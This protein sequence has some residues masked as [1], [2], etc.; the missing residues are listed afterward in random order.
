MSKRRK[1]RHKHKET[2]P[3]KNQS[4][5]DNPVVQTG[6]SI[7]PYTPETKNDSNHNEEEHPFWKR[8]LPRIGI[9]A[10]IAYAVITWFMYCANKR[11]ADAAHSAASTAREA[12]VTGQRA[13]V[14]N[15][16]QQKQEGNFLKIIV[17]LENNGETPTRYM[18]MH[19]SQSGVMDKPLPHDFGFPNT[20][21]DGIDHGGIKVTVAAKSSINGIEMLVPISQLQKSPAYLYV[22]G[23]ATYYD[24]FENT[25]PHILQ[26]CDDFSVHPIPYV[27]TLESADA[28][29]RHNCVDDACR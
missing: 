24:A 14:F 18:M 22:W 20:W 2:E 4:G 19:M 16:F 25:P 26:F 8:W 5:T 9:F 13:Y 1:P 21:E 17:R 3:K 29:Y 7:Q 23:W 6:Q 10:G 28:C 12:L 15:S 11:S 27:Q